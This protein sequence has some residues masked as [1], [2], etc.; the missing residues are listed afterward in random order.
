MTSNN[1]VMSVITMNKSS[2][3]SRNRLKMTPV[4]VLWN[5]M[6]SCHCAEGNVCLLMDERLVCGWDVN[7]DVLLG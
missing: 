5:Q 2:C 6:A 1:E 7:N 4:W 3:F